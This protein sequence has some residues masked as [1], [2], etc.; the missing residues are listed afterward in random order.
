MGQE[1]TF[2]DSGGK[3]KVKQLLGGSSHLVSIDSSHGDRKSRKFLGFF[4]FQMAD[5]EGGTVPTQIQ[6][7]P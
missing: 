4:L 2:I 7:I 1:P 5:L 6:Q 3:H